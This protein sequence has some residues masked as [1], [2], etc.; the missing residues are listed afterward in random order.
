MF[1][2]WRHA[3]LTRCVSEE[4]YSDQRPFRYFNEI[5]QRARIVRELSGF[6][7][8]QTSVGEPAS[9][10]SFWAL[11]VFR[12]LA[13]RFLNLREFGFG[14]GVGW[15]GAKRVRRCAILWEATRVRAFWVPR[16]VGFNAIAH[17]VVW[18][19]GVGGVER[20]VQPSLHTKQIFPSLRHLD[21]SWRNLNPLL[22]RRFLQFFHH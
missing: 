22:M 20:C 1:N 17:G 19:D 11:Q 15:S 21:T 2:P 4:S 18:V 8:E 14:P 16:W 10:C 13:V 6:G 7:V 12:I 5:G 3:D 9:L